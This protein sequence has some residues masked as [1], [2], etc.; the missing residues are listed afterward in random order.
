MIDDEGASDAVAASLG[1][2]VRNGF[3]EWLRSDEKGNLVIDRVRP[4]EAWQQTLWNETVRYRVDY[5][6]ACK[7]TWALYSN[8]MGVSI[9]DF[10]GMPAEGPV[11]AVQNERNHLL[12]YKDIARESQFMINKLAQHLGNEIMKGENVFDCAIRLIQRAK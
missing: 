4:C 1:L 5:M 6:E 8:A 9:R 2:R 7:T 12:T 3:V 11:Q 10:D